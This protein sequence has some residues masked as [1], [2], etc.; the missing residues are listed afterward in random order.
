MSLLK[1]TINA[2]GNVVLYKG[3]E[4]LVLPPTAHWQ[5]YVI[6]KGWTV[7]PPEAAAKPAAAP[8]VRVE[9]EP[10]KPAADTAKRRRD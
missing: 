3:A 9:F 6:N 5:H 4:T 7:A 8:P 1:P 2:D 10:D